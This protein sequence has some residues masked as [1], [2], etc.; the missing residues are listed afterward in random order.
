MTTCVEYGA[1]LVSAA[2]N[3]YFKAFSLKAVTDWLEEMG[4]VTPTV[5]VQRVWDGEAHDRWAPVTA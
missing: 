4:D 3:V 2:A 1:Q 5:L